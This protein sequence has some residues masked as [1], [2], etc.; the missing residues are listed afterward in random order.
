[1][2]HVPL[3]ACLLAAACT[4]TGLHANVS[5]DDR[6]GDATTMDIH[7]PSG[8]ATGRPAIMLIHGGAWRFGEKEAC[9]VTKRRAL[10][11]HFADRTQT[12]FESRQFTMGG[13]QD[14]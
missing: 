10:A 5:Y 8:H 9:R 4:D 13:A 12:G 14:L 2:R 3:T 7:V 1:M 11:V 6:F